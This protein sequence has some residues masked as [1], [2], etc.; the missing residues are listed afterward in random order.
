[1]L[2][3]EQAVQGIPAS[4]AQITGNLGTIQAAIA[5]A[6]IGVQAAQV[7]DQSQD[8][9]LAFNA[10][11]V[12][13]TMAQATFTAWEQ[14]IAASGSAWSTFGLS[15]EEIPIIAEGAEAAI[16]TGN[17]ELSIIQSQEQAVTKSGQIA[18]QQALV[19]LTEATIPAWTQVQTSVDN[20]RASVASIDADVNQMHL[21]QGQAA[22]Q[23]AVGTGQDFVSVA[24]QEVPIPVDTVL[25]RQASATEER[26]QIA[27]TN[28][29]ALAYM[30]RRAVEQRIG[31]TLDALT[32]SVG[33]IDA[34]ASWA[35]DICSLQ[36]VNYASLSTAVPG[37]P[38]GG[39]SEA[40]RR[41]SGCESRRWRLSS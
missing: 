33:P 16:N 17:Q 14:E 23:L 24:G 5:Q 30:A 7:A 11:G 6:L 20:L 3:A 18:M 12:Q 34:P 9:Q 4:W 15:L 25:R 2:Q 1:M 35:D 31:V 10:A 28:A 37:G 27:L 39:C 32:Q 26:Y 36:G 38:D 29:K 8:L 41:S 40:S 21:T 22:Y 19:A 13:G